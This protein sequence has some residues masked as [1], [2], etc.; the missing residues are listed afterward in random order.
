MFATARKDLKWG[1]WRCVL[2]Q[3]LVRLPIAK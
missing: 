2:P 1:T 3:R